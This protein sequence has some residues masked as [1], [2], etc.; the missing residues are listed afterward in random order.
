MKVHKNIWV[1]KEFWDLARKQDINIS[2]TVNQLLEIITGVS[3]SKTE[4]KKQIDE[5]KQEV[6]ALEVKL[7]QLKVKHGMT[8]DE[9]LQFINENEAYTPGKKEEIKFYLLKSV[10]LIQ[11]DIT[12]ATGRALLITK[13]FGLDMNPK[14][15][16]RFSNM[17]GEEQKLCTCDIPPQHRNELVGQRCGKCLG[18]IQKHRHVPLGEQKS[19][20][21]IAEMK[22]EHDEK[23]S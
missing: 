18:I 11:D 7:Q 3:D 8:L 2:Q 10:E 6:T 13:K 12:Y 20:D 15:L 5:K 17:T 1:D 14:M 9:Y 19:K 21:I 22:K 4:I 16:I 23:K